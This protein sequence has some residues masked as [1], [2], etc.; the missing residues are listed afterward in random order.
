MALSAGTRLGPYEIVAR[1]GAGGMGEVYRAV[2][3]TLKRQAAIKV[4]PAASAWDTERVARLEREAQTLAALNH[5]HIATI[6]G[7]ERDGATFALAMELV[8]GPTLADRIADGTVPIHEACT[9]ARQIAE[10]LEAAH[11]QGI[12]HRD[13]KPAN[14]KIRPDGAVKV[15]DFGLAKALGTEAASAAAGHAPDLPTVTTPALVTATGIIMGTAAY[16]SPEQ[17]R[18]RTVDKRTDVWAFGCVF[19]EMLTGRR[20][21]KGN[22][23][24]ETLAAVTRD[25]PDW[26]AL[27]GSVPTVVTALLQQCLAKAPHE[28][29]ANMSAAITVLRLPTLRVSVPVRRPGAAARLA[30]GLAGAFALGAAATYLIGGTRGLPLPS[31][32]PLIRFEIGAPQ[33]S[34]FSPGNSLA[35]SPDGKQLVFSVE[36]EGRSSLWV[37]PVGSTEARELAGTQ[38][39]DDPFWAPDG[40]SVAFFADGKLKRVSLADG[41]VL[42]LCEA[43]GA[44]GGS[45]GPNDDILIGQASGPLLHVPAAGGLAEPA[46]PLGGRQQETS[47]RWP[48]WL[49]DGRFL[50]IS[51]AADGALVSI[52]T[53]GT[54]AGT[55]LGSTNSSAVYAA[56]H[57]LFSRGGNLLAQRLNLSRA[58]LEGVPR[59]M[60]PVIT[61]SAANMRATFAATDAGLLAFL[62]RVAGY[63]QFVWKDR[64][65]TDLQRVGEPGPFLQFRLSPNGRQAV[66]QRDGGATASVWVLDAERGVA[67]LLASGQGQGA[68]IWSPDGRVSYTLHSNRGDLFSASLAGGAPSLVTPLPWNSYVEDWSSDGRFAAVTTPSAIEIVE[69]DT[70]KRS[71]FFAKVGGAP[72]DEAAFSPDGQWLALMSAD[73]GRAEVYLHPFRR[74]GG[75]HKVS[76]SGGSSPKWRADGRELYY[77]DLDGAIMA[78]EVEPGPDARMGNPRVLFRT[79]VVRNILVDQYAPTSDGQRFLV[80]EPA[81]A[82]AEVPISVIANWP[83]MLAP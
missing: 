68:P 60:G 31:A 28:R 75:R 41:T 55:A 83:S 65:G 8:E 77:L 50:Y 73:S 24:V 76:T 48:Q 82:R 37:R 49:P 26:S 35:F 33:G 51:V 9:I 7:V 79:R 70:G 53:P 58:Q 64:R 67:S 38:A 16:M 72:V 11:E 29:P 80:L 27:P 30:L 13:L 63:R 40:Q 47:H 46:M 32:S 34:S 21:F 52:A 15:L 43:P 12:I 19:Y 20:A 23:V 4:L 45:W 66:V 44:L 78:T 17:A 18:G 56:G 10:A 59:P 5:P 81:G 57:L 61:V 54:S 42:T 2:D 6:F 62:P 14:I 36:R 39:A 25:E 71:M 69:R 74:G 22:D 1:I 3:L